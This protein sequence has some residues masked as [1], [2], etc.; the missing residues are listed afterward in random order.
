M[1]KKPPAKGGKM[2][3]GMPMMPPAKGGKPPFPPKGGKKK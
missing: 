2:P 3:P 1:A